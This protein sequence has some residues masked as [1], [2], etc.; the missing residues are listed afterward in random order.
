MPIASSAICSAT[1]PPR[2]PASIPIAWFIPT[3][4]PGSLRRSP[5]WF[6]AQP[7]AGRAKCASCAP[8]GRR[9][10]CSRPRRR[11]GG[12]PRRSIS[13]QAIDIEDRKRAEATAAEREQRWNVALESAGQGVWD[14]DDRKAHAFYS[15]TWKEIRGLDQ[16]QLLRRNAR[17]VDGAR[18]IPT[19]S[20]AYGRRWSA[21]GPVIWASRSPSIGSGM[22]TAT[23]SGS[24]AG[25]KTVD[26]NPDGTPARMVGT[27]TDITSLKAIEELTQFANTVLTTAMETSP[28]AILVDRRQRRG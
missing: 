22:R 15:R 28:D 26:W 18:S 20:A 24:S 21:R 17:R 3:M 2:C 9:S 25:G 14:H 13:V 19:I 7:S 12:T 23:G 4:S 27:D 1:M 6:R 8:T 16:V 10:G 5:G 11:Y